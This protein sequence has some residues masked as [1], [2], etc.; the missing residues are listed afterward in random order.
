MK[1]DEKIVL[2]LGFG[3]AVAAL[4]YMVLNRQQTPV[5]NPAGGFTLNLPSSSAT[6]P[7]YTP[8]S[9]T[10]ELPSGQSNPLSNPGSS[11]VFG[12]LPA[13]T[14]PQPG[15]ADG[16]VTAPCGCPT[17]STGTTGA[18]GTEGDAASI[19][20]PFIQRLAN[21]LP[22]GISSPG[23]FDPGAQNASQA[24]LSVFKQQQAAIFGASQVAFSTV[25][26]NGATTY[27]GA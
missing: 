27:S 10:F 2:Y 5:A 25:A 12:F 14:A 4:A 11:V 8:S 7:T 3:L 18:Y 16:G 21:E 24:E 13:S 6:P 20:A 15:S 19:L 1:P 23:I 22:T 26:A 9:Y 17:G